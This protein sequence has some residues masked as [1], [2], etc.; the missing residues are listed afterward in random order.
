MDM[1]YGGNVGGRGCAGW[2]GVKG[3]KWDN[4]NSIINKIYFKKQ[5]PVLSSTFTICLGKW[6]PRRLLSAALVL[7]WTVRLGVAWALDTGRGGTD[8]KM[9]A[10]AAALAHRQMLP[11]VATPLPVVPDVWQGTHLW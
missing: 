5:S 1:N 10:G 7:S 4:C 11:R 8:G 9:R 2:S 3:R 6:V